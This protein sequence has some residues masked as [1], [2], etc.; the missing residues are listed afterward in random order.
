MC[1]EIISTDKAPK[2][3]GP[4]SQAIKTKG[5]VFTSGQIAINPKTGRIEAKEI[6][7]QVRQCLENISAV[8][9]SAGTGRENILKLTV[10]MIDLADFSKLNEVFLEYFPKDQP[11]RSAVQVLRLPLDALVEIEAIAIVE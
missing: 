6:K 5:I 11:A 3:I 1:R 2:A 8:L 7:A 10:F 9:T 4:Y